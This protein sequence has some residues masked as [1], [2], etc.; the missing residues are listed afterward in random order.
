MF[1]AS[2]FTVEVKNVAATDVVNVSFQSLGFFPTA[3][4]AGKKLG[5]NGGYLFEVTL[6]QDTVVPPPSFEFF[7]TAHR[8]ADNTT[9]S[10]YYRTVDVV[11][12]NNNGGC[13]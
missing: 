2:T 1:R 5:P 8:A 11:Q 10:P 13:H 12:A 7:V 9:S 3:S 6:A 4:N